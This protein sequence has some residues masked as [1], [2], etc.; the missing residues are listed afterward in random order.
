M[1][2]GQAPWMVSADL[3]GDERRRWVRD[4]VL[5]EDDLQL[6]LTG[7]DGFLEYAEHGGSRLAQG[8]R[9]VAAGEQ[10]GGEQGRGQVAGPV[11]FER[12]ARRLHEPV[13]VVVHGEHLDRRRPAVGLVDSG[14]PECAGV[15]ESTLREK[16]GEI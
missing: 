1:G 3:A 15:R 10:A 14:Y 13:A 12:Q 5:A 7:V 16:H 6:A 9:G 11:R 4:R 2:P 8:L